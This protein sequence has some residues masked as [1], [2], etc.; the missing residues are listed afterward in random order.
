M[1]RL[2]QLLSQLLILIA[3]IGS[4]RAIVPTVAAQSKDPTPRYEIGLGGEALRLNDLGTSIGGISGRFSYFLTNNLAL[5]TSIAYFP[6]EGANFGQT[7]GLFGVR[8]GIRDPRYGIFAKIRPGFVRFREDDRSLLSNDRTK[9]ALDLGFT[10]EY[11]DGPIGLRYDIG[12]TLIFF[13]EARSFNGKR[14]GTTSN[15]QNS[16]SI[17]LRF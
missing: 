2:S 10:L 7:Q 6:Q 14:L 3:L 8:A 12:N 15:F 9:G 16:V 5:D 11:Y 1:P 4:F 13:G 17:V